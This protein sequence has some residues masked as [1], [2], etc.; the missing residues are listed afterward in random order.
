MDYYCVTCSKTIKFSKQSIS[1]HNSSMSHKSRDDKKTK[2]TYA[3]VETIICIDK[4]YI[5]INKTV[6]M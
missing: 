1:R 4:V 2:Y 3:N 6:L 5:I